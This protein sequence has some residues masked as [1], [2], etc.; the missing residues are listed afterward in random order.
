MMDL[1]APDLLGTRIV[2]GLRVPLGLETE[3]L[4]MAM[5][6]KNTSLELMPGKEHRGNLTSKCICSSKF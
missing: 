5:L 1:H 2:V 3:L 4:L 6:S